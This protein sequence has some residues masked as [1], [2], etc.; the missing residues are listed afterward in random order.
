[1]DDAKKIIDEAEREGLQMSQ[2]LLKLVQ[3]GRA[4]CRERV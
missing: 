4:S 1:M 2:G 3:I